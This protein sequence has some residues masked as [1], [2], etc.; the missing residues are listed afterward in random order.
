MN[1]WIAALNFA[2][3]GAV[4]LLSV[5]GLWFTVIIPGIGRWSR[6]FFMG[7]FIIFLLCDLSCIAETALQ[8][9]RVPGTLF[10]FV[11]ALENLLLSL[12]LPMLTVY[13][14]HCS[15][16]NIRASKLLRAVLGLW[17]VYCILAASAAFLDQTALRGVSFAANPQ[18][19]TI[20]DSAF[21]SCTS[22]KKISIPWS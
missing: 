13:L 20:E 10:D 6:R 21:D 11:L 22:L 2:I 7:Y 18:F 1:G 16:E 12:P 5:V 3:T 14:L 19:T 15:G 4:L 17:A 8:Y 9:Y